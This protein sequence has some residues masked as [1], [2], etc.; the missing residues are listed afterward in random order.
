MGDHRC[1]LFDELAVLE[2]H[3]KADYQGSTG[4]LHE[5]GGSGDEEEAEHVARIRYRISADPG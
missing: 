1:K 3:W 2:Y 5:Q 4:H